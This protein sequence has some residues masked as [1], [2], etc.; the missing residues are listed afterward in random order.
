MWVLPRN[1][2]T[3]STGYF[4][5][6]AASTIESQSTLIGVSLQRYCRPASNIRYLHHPKP[7]R[8]ISLPFPAT[9]L[10]P[11]GSGTSGDKQ[12]AKPET[13][14]R[15]LVKDGGVMRDPLGAEV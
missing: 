5:R 15:P 3:G 7:H 14:P 6:N 4:I 9:Y 12:G 2:N 13:F 10:F 11:S 8:G 1:I